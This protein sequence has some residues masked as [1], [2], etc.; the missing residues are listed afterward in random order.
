MSVQLHKPSTFQVRLVRLKQ[1]IG[2]FG[3]VLV[4]ATKLSDKVDRLVHSVERT[5]VRLVCLALTIIGAL[6]LLSLKVDLP[7][8]IEK[9]RAIFS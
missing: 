2:L 8:L 4:E 3:E 6:T 7:R 5:F 1:N 9:L